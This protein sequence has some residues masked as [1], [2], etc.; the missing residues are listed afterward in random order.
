MFTSHRIIGVL[1]LAGALQT[2]PAT[3]AHG[4]SNK[5]ST[6]DPALRDSFMSEVG[7]LLDIPEGLREEVLISQKEYEHANPVDAVEGDLPYRRSVRVS[8]LLDEDGHMLTHDQALSQGVDVSEEFQ[9]RSNPCDPLVSQYLVEEKGF[10]AT[11]LIFQLHQTTGDAI[12]VH[13]NVRDVATGQIMQGDRTIR[14]ATTASARADAL[15]EVWE[16]S[17]F[18]DTQA[19]PVRDNPASRSREIE[20]AGSDECSIRMRLGEGAEEVVVTYSTTEDFSHYHVAAAEGAELYI[21][22]DDVA[23]YVPG[24]MGWVDMSSI[25]RGSSFGWGDIRDQGMAP[26]MG[27]IDELPIDITPNAQ[28]EELMPRLPWWLASHLGWNELWQ[29]GL[30]G[31]EAGEDLATVSCPNG[32]SDCVEIEINQGTLTYDERRRLVAIGLVEQDMVLTFEYGGPEWVSTRP[33]GW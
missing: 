27:G 4:S 33:P 29:A 32:G 5:V 31:D 20:V 15:V 9:V 1:A 3:V 12:E 18:V 24:G 25:M 28:M 30:L 10:A 17:D 16:F 6:I 13:A 8:V 19:L 26:D 2:L 21:A 14:D 11:Q 23:V 7:A 22:Q